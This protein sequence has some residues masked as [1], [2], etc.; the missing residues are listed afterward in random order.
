MGRL[1][2]PQKNVR[3]LG[4]FIESLYLA[5]PLL[6][7]INFLSIS[8]VLYTNVQDYLKNWIPWM[9]FPVFL[10]IIFILTGVAVLLT[11]IFLVPSLWALRG[12]QMFGKET[13]EEES[14]AKKKS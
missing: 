2:I 11:W 1:R 9:T 10:T 4:A 7:I 5:L 14:N 12:Q 13:R 3:W 6:S 8:V